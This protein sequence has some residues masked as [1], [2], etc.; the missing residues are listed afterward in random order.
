MVS[1]SKIKASLKYQRTSSKYKAYKKQ[2]NAEYVK[3]NYYYT[4]ACSAKT[5]YYKKYS[6]ETAKEK[7]KAYVMKQSLT[8]KQFVRLML[9]L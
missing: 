5:Y 8:G 3:K 4:K 9:L 6:K 7:F 2:Y 1:K